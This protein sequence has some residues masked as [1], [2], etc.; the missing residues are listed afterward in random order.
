MLNDKQAEAYLQRM[1][2]EDDV[3]IE[4]EV[5]DRLVFAHQCS[6]P[7]ETVTLHRSGRAPSLKTETLFDKIVER[8]LGGYCFELNKLFGELLTALGFHVRPVLCRAVR[9]RKERMPVNHRGILAD[10]EGE[11]LFLD[12]GFGGPMA[13]ST[14]VLAET[15]DQLI[16]G[17]VFAAID[18]GKSWWR[19]ERVTQ[20]SLDTY[21][22]G[23]A[24]HRQIELEVCTASSDDQDFEALNEFCSKP[25]TLFRDHEIVNLRT[26]EGYRG[27]KDGVLTIRDKG[28]KTIR[29]LLPQEIDKVL[30]EYFG[31]A[32]VDAYV[33]A[34]QYN[35]G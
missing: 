10:L 11:I 35:H 32:D 6:I 16:A 17:E 26:A 19:I 33:R 4:K 1:G 12:V 23:V 7:F 31:M 34:R 21:D 20:G 15:G 24:A 3:K 9:G 18:Q 5:L 13:P 30:A 25:G 14:L 22:D 8:R 27:L 29:E 2:F 28:K